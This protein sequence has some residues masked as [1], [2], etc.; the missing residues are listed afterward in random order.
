MAMEGD[1][2]GL[3]V[4]PPVF[5]LCSLFEALHPTFARL[6]APP[7]PAKGA[8]QPRRVVPRKNESTTK[9]KRSTKLHDLGGGVG[10]RRIET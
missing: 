2:V 4:E 10:R 8:A 7:V 6:P 1:N 3:A 9:A 5:D